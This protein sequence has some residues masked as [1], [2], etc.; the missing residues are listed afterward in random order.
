MLQV[1]AI[2]NSTNESMTDN[3]PVSNS[4]YERAGSGLKEEIKVDIRGG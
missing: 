1:D 3:N 2:V 4:I